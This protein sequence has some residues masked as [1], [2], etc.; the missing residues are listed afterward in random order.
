MKVADKNAGSS[1]VKSKH[2][3]VGHTEMQG[4]AAFW[5]ILKLQEMTEKDRYFSELVEENHTGCL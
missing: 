1:S 3:F 4:S 5:T 2:H